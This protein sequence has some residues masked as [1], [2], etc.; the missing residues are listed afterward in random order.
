MGRMLVQMVANRPECRLSGASERTE[1]DLIGRD[2]G[3]LGGIGPLGIPV[4]DDPRPLFANSQVVIDFTLP[5]ATLRHVEIAQAGGVPL[6]IGTTGL[7]A[8]GLSK[9][10]AAATKIPIVMAP[11]FSLGVNL[12]FQVAAD[13]AQVLGDAFD[14]E[15][16]EAHHRHKVDA[17]SGTALGLGRAIAQ[18]IGRDLDQVAVYGRQGE[19]GARDSQTIGFST[20]RGGDIVGEHTALFVGVGER[21]EITHRVSSRLT[22]ASGAVHAA[23]WLQN[24]PP[25]LYDMGDILG[26]KKS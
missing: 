24:Q 8:A 23:L 19:T 15:I 1:S 5:P 21:F 17:P 11:N 20:I 25:G 16:I 6:V 13:V 3:E 12:M 7:D 14:I 2:A 26:F 18:A 22:F 9:I 10:Q 4:L